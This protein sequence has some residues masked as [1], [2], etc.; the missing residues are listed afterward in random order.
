VFTGIAGA[1]ASLLFLVATGAGQLAVV[2]VITALY[3]AVT[4][5][6]ARVL[7]TERWTRP[8]IVGLLAAAAATALIALS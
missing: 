4:V 3:P 2:A 1:V 5:V 7:L 8:Q 6:L